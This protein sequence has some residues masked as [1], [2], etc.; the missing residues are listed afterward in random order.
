MRSLWNVDQVSTQV[1]VGFRLSIDLVSIE[2]IDRHLMVDGQS[3]HDPTKALKQTKRG[4]TFF[5]NTEVCP[6][7]PKVSRILSSTLEIKAKKKTAAMITYL[8]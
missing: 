8:I 4:Y 1:S 3:T 7:K 6:V 2:G 5:Q